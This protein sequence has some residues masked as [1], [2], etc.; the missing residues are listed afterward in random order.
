MLLAESIE[1]VFESNNGLV[2]CRFTKHGNFIFPLLDLVQHLFAESQSVEYFKNVF[3]RQF[4]SLKRVHISVPIYV[5]KYF[6]IKKYVRREEITFKLW[7][8]KYI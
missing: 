8:I 5:F 3:E 2:S 4:Y 7:L 6:P 1:I